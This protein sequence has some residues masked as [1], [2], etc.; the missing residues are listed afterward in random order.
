MKRPLELFDLDS[1]AMRFNSIQV[2]VFYGIFYREFQN[3]SLFHLFYVCFRF[4]FRFRLF[5]GLV[6]VYP[7]RSHCV[8]DDMLFDC[9]K[10]LDETPAAQ[11]M[12]SIYFNIVQVLVSNAFIFTPPLNPFL[13]HNN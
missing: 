7:I 8:C 5:G 1:D 12:G 11:L 3:H 6:G 13:N 4:C 2:D 10:K 9:L